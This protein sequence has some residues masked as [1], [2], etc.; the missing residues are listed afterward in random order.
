MLISIAVLVPI[1]MTLH[2]FLTTK[3][4]FR[5]A[6]TP[7][8]GTINRNAWALQNK[9][10]P[11]YI[12][13]GTAV[14]STAIHLGVLISYCCSVRASNA[15]DTFGTWVQSI[16][17]IGQLVLWA[18]VSAI[19]KYEK[20]KTENGKHNDLWGWTC[21]G[22]AQAIQKTFKDVVPFNDYCNI[23]TAGWYAG[24]VQIGAILLAIVI[25]VLVWRRKKSKAA[26]RMSAA[27][28]LEGA[29]SYRH[30]RV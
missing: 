14:V 2:K 13:F 5:E 11:T 20:E 9:M 30:R 21:S 17:L 3:D 26:V 22:P 6:P 16:E 12:F 15:V 27:R 1:S 24:L 8:G 18:V 7:T 19:Y 28:G 23:Q 4:T 25:W 29:E 10:W